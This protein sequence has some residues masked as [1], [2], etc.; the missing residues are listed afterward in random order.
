MTDRMPLIHIVGP[1]RLQ[2]ELFHAFMEKETGLK[3]TFSPG[4]GIPSIVEGESQPTCLLLWDCLSTD[5]AG[6]WSEQGFETYRAL[7]Q[8]LI[9]LFNVE[10]GKGMEREALES[11]VRGIFYSHEPMERFPKGVQ[12]ILKGE[13]WYPRK[14][15]SECLLGQKMP[16]QLTRKAANALTKR[17]E[18]I[19]VKIARGSS[20]EDIAKDLFISCHT[21]KTHVYNIFKK[22][23]VSNRI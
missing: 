3:C 19:L 16:V 9:A 4:P 23:N 21:V 18:E 7:S 22:I 11:G 17:E 5:L 12:A 2:N 15:F 20:N 1:N 6:L 10:A 13:L 14:F 8:Y